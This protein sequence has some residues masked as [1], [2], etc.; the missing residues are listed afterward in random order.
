MEPPW[1]VINFVFKGERRSVAA[2]EDRGSQSRDK[3]DRSSR[4]R[5]SRDRSDRPDSKRK[6]RSRLDIY[7]FFIVVFIVLV[8]WSSVLTKTSSSDWRSLLK[9]KRMDKS[10]NGGS[11]VIVNDQ[12]DD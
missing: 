7:W 11:I 6:S 5:S 3:D 2:D 1:F 12:P 10:I 8:N 9:P 4:D